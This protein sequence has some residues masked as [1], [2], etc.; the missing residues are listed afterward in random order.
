M[1]SYSAMNSAANSANSIAR[2]VPKFSLVTMLMV[3]LSY[4]ALANNYSTGLD[5]YIS[6]DFEKA[7]QHWLIAAKDGDAK[8]MFNLGLMY[9]QSKL[10]NNRPN[11]AERWYRKAAENGYHAANFH[12]AQRLFERGGSDDQAL[13]LVN[14]AAEKGYAPAKRYLSKSGVASSLKGSNVISVLPINKSSLTQESSIRA[15]SKYLNKSW[16][17]KQPSSNWTIQLLA[18]K[19]ESKV[20]NFID[21]YDLNSKAAYFIENKDGIKWYKLIYG[22]YDSKDKASFSRQNLSKELQEFGPWL[23]TIGSVQE[24]TNN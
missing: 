19:D 7:E 21:D 18:F 22:S 3:L 2:I 14:I 20:K 13:E 24:F 4:Q 6:K 15:N 5:A 17:N 16:I 11:E 12:L 1:L 9:E 23:R 10:G 8:S